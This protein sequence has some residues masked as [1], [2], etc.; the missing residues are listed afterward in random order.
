MDPLPSH[1]SVDV[2]GEVMSFSLAHCRNAETS[3]RRQRLEWEVAIFLGTSGLVL[4]FSFFFVV[5]FFIFFLG[6]APFAGP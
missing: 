4:G 5:F 1:V 2:N 6:G 3:R